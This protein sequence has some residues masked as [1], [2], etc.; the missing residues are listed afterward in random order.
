MPCGVGSHHILPSIYQ[1]R[2]NACMAL[3]SLNILLLQGM[4]Q[5]EIKSERHVG[6]A[7]QL[8]YISSVHLGSKRMVN[9]KVL[10]DFGGVL[11]GFIVLTITIC[12]ASSFFTTNTLYG[13][14]KGTY[15]R[16]IHRSLLYYT[17]HAC[18][19]CP[20][21]LTSFICMSLDCPLIVPCP[22]PLP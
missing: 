14:L 15:L 16:G 5:G 21:P 18:P 4:E 8:Q 6:E 7:R 20:L 1:A 3:Q 10:C 17:L 22:L 9:L 2:C 13:L 12:E 19:P 11:I